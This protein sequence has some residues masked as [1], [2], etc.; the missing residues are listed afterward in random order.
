MRVL[1]L[2]LVFLL[3]GCGDS[4]AVRDDP[5]FERVIPKAP[6]WARVS[7]STT[8]CTCVAYGE[9]TD[10]ARGIAADPSNVYVT[11]MTEGDLDGNVNARTDLRYSTS[12]DVFLMKYDGAGNKAWTRQFGSPE[13]DRAEDVVIDASGNVYVSG[14]TAGALN[15]NG[16]LGSSDAFIAKFDG[17]GNRQWLEQF[18]TPED[19]NA[20]GVAI[21]GTGFVYVA[22]N[23]RGGLDG[24]AN[25]GDVDVFLRKYDP[26]GVLQWTRL[27]GTSMTDAVSGVETA[28]D[29]SIYVGG[30]E[31]VGDA[32]S[33]FLAKFDGTGVVQWTQRFGAPGFVIAPRLDVNPTGGPS[34]VG[35]DPA[36]NVYMVASYDPNGGN[37][38][39][40]D[41]DV[42]LWKFDSAGTQLWTGT[43]AS[44]DHDEPNGLAVDAQ[45]N[46]LVTGV[47]RGPFDGHADP[48]PND[49]GDNFDNDD[50]F[51]VKWDAAGNKLWSRVFS[52]WGWDRGFGVA[53]GTAAS[54]YVAGSTT[55]ALD[56]ESLSETSAD[57][58]VIKLDAEGVEVWR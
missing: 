32:T 11:G 56:P 49:D 33:L 9:A 22:G 45:G 55:N 28:A 19:D 27:L 57:I 38:H 58:F 35:V 3:V 46:V 40:D 12:A 18:G 17:N 42:I 14:F 47:T 53:S 4:T 31:R 13:P 8:T 23:T 37:F 20:F 25:R 43:A 10:E 2:P 52:S 15:E 1:S 24:N 5:S 34:G 41:S 48:E 36:G 51:V 44:P 39:W 30:T 50:A 29:G 26:E 21:D 16:S 6:P 7:G 54:T